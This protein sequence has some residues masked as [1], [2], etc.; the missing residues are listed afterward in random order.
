M[1]F[2]AVEVLTFFT[3][4]CIGSFLNV[5]IYR[6]PEGKSIVYPPSACP[7]CG[8][9]LSWWQNIPVLSFILLRGRC[10]ACAGPISWQYP[11][12]EVLSGCIAVLLLLRFGPGPELAAYSIFCAA[13]VVISFIDLRLQI[14]PDVISIPGMIA[15]LAA[16]FFVPSV[17]IL[18]SVTGLLLGGGILFAVAWGYYLITRREGLG[19]GDIKLLAMIG[20]FLGWKAVPLV[21]FLS[22]TAGSV[23]GLLMVLFR[24]AGRHTAIPYGP[25][26]A[27]GG[28]ICLFA[29]DTLLHFYF[30][31]L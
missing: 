22:A 31:L 27:L 11:V 19:G 30:S 25:F 9:A 13:L 20:A 5:C 18:D 17:S 24:G 12:V 4:A 16:S 6:I 23:A 21:L 15:G 29:G 1:S 14:I 7:H 2:P 28:V 3:G 10:A 8:K 26:L